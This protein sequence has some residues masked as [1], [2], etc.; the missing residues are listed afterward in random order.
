MPTII[1][2]AERVENVL[3]E[4]MEQ[5]SPSVSAV[6]VFSEVVKNAAER[7]L[8]SNVSSSLNPETEALIARMN[9]QRAEGGALS[10]NEIAKVL[11][12]SR[13]AVDERRRRRKLVAWR[14]TDG[15][16]RYPVWQFGAGGTLP[17]IVECLAALEYDDQASIMDFFL[18]K[19]EMLDGMRPLDM[20]RIGN[21]DKAI[22]AAKSFGVYG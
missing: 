8:D 3:V 4:A 2:E 14:M 18:L 19:S 5:V 22:E 16:W 17:G 7:I 21:M 15:K 20:I 13:Q 12:L 10:S 6:E 1:E 9:V 11:G